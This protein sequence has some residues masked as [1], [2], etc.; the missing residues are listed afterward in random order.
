MS[1]W[2]NIHLHEKCLESDA[3]SLRGSPTIKEGNEYRQKERIK[4]R[5]RDRE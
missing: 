2:L 5:K 4:E 1:N 3:W